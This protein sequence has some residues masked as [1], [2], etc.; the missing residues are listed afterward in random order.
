VCDAT[1][2]CLAA[3]TTCAL[4]GTSCGDAGQCCSGQCLGGV[5]GTSCA[6]P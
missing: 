6:T 2:A 4:L 5:C 1:G 3:A